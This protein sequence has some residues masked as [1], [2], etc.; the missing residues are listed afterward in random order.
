MPVRGKPGDESPRPAVEYR[1]A[2]H[3]GG[4]LPHNGDMQRLRPTLAHTLED[5]WK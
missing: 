4:R 2:P 1:R 3:P 5:D